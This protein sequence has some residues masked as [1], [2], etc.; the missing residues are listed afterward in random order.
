MSLPA[1]AAISRGASDR[2]WA[3]HARGFVGSVLMVGC[4]AAVAFSQSAIP[5]LAKFEMRLQAI[6]WALFVMGAGLRF[7]STLYIGGRKAVEVV[8]E[9]PYSICRNPL[10]LGT[11]F[12]A[13]SFAVMAQSVAILVAVLAAAIYYLLAAMPAEEAALAARLGERYREY[14]R[15]TPRIVPRLSLFHTPKEL[16]VNVK[17][18]RNELGRACRWLWAPMLAQLIVALR[19]EAWWPH[20]FT[21]P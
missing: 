18:L 19:A 1:N 4:G 20:W 14:C 13:L 12:V 10:Y 17:A 15:R 8:S 7:W 3:F 9:G 16:T 5:Y 6:G 11:L 2:L 21:L